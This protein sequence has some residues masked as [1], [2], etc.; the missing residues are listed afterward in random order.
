[1][2]NFENQTF[3]PKLINCKL[4]ANWKN[5]FQESGCIILKAS[6]EG[7][8]K[9]DEGNI[10][11]R[12]VSVEFSSP[13]GIIYKRNI[14]IKEDAV[15]VIPVLAG[16]Q[17][18]RFVAV[19]QRRIIDG[20]Y[21]IEF[22]SGGVKSSKSR[23]ISAIDELREETGIKIAEERLNTLAPNLVVCE[24]SFNEIVTWYHC[25]LSKSEFPTEGAKHGVESENEHTR[26]RLLSKQDIR[27]I[28]S[29]HM[30]TAYELLTRAGIILSE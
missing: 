3:D 16:E 11:R 14:L 5:R 8:I 19:E 29:F 28:P 6:S 20:N 27:E 15:I 10:L 1:M 21:S 18:K 17:D 2:H 13:E 7:E 4:F 25:T 9:T 12:L 30:V 22:P 24:S 23:V 26:I